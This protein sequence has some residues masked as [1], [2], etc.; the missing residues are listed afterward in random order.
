MKAII[1]SILDVDLY[2]FTMMQAVIKKFPNAKVKYE[3]FNRG[4]HKFPEDFGI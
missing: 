3:F 4:D 1:R 2:K